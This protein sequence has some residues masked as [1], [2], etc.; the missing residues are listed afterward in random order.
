MFG[1]GTQRFALSVGMRCVAMCDVV[2]RV[3]SEE[4]CCVRRFLCFLGG[5]YTL[6][7]VVVFFGT[8]CLKVAV[9]QGSG[10]T[11]WV[12]VFRE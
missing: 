2:C 12:G 6:W 8:P 3:V 4:W 7:V 10:Y 5:E 9:G 1:I 11:L